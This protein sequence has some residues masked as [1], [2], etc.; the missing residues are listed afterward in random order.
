MRILTFSIEGQKLYKYGDFSHIV[1]NT[2]QYLKCSFNFV[3]ADWSKYKRIAVFEFEDN[4]Y[5]IPIAGD[6]TCVVPDEVTDRRYFK[7]KVVG[8]KK[9][10]TLT[11]TKEII[12]QEG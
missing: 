9:D 3:D 6:N 8:V 1:R 12:E 5:A 4:E 7:L 10:G 2:K 11:T